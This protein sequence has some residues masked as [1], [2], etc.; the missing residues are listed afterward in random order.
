[1]KN[2]DPE[3]LVFIDEMGV[4]L[5]LTRTHARSPYGERVYDLKPFYRGAKVTVIGAISLKKVKDVMT[6]NASMDGNAN[7]SIY[8]K[9]FASSIMAGCCSCY[10]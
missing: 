9:M 2:I 1:M 7:E 5:G 4:L 10:G 6:M 3:N 8:S